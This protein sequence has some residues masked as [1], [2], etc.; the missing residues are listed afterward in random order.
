MHQKDEMQEVYRALETAEMI[1]IAS[2]IYYFGFSGQLQC[3]IH[4]TYAV[5]I[6]KNLRKAM[7]ILSSGSNGVYEGAIYEYRQTFLEYMGLQDVGIFKA[8]GSQN[9]SE[10]LLSRLRQAGEEL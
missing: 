1:V 10:G 4:R 9:K 3:A 2:P 8:Y 7:L 5:G 6:P